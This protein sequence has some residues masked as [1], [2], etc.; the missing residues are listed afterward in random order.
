MALPPIIEKSQRKWLFSVTKELSKQAE[1]DLCL[2]GYFFGTGM[3]TLQINRVQLKDVLHKS[4][5]LCAEF[6]IKGT[7]HTFYLVSKLL[8]KLTNDYLQYRVKHKIC[9]GNNPDQYLGLD[10]DEPLFISSSTKGNNKGFSIV[11]KTTSIGNDSYTCNAL[12]RHLIHLMKQAGIEGGSI[13]SGRR[14]FCVTLHRQGFDLAHIHRL[15]NNKTLET[16]QKLLT[17]DT[18]DMAAIAKQAF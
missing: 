7:D 2:L 10:G 16:T 9:L 5:K 15:L 6:K 4:G 3:T 14:T 8:I 18:V 13:L 12:N 1:R 17:T 11:K